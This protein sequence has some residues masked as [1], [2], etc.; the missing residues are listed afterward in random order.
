M[1]PSP[2]GTA[3]CMARP[4]RF[5]RRAASARLSAPAAASA[6]YSPSEWPATKAALAESFQPPSLSST[7]KHR[8]AH[9]HQRRLGV[10][11][12]GQIGFRPLE[13]QPRQALA[14][15][16]VDLLEDDGAPSRRPRPGPGPCRRPGSPGPGKTK[17]VVIQILPLPAPAGRKWRALRPA[18]AGVSR[19]TARSAP[20]GPAAS[21]RA[22]AARLAPRRGALRQRQRAETVEKP[23]SKDSRS[24][25][26]EIDLA[27]AEALQR[28]AEPAQARPSRS[29]RTRSR[30]ISSGIT[31]S[32]P[33]A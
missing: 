17:A 23:A 27:V 5:S 21:E 11:G 12:Q 32:S 13:H 6:E 25:D 22:P 14:Q 26:R 19:R 15:R 10:L 20:T 16:V 33:P 8:Q 18:P 28:L 29:R 1:A 4:R 2:T 24:I 3:R 31:S 7:R 9:R 30:S